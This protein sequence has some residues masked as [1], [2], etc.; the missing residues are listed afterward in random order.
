MNN[1][2]LKKFR[3]SIEITKA[4]KPSKATG[5]AF[6]STLIF[7]KNKLISIGVNNYNKT[8]PLIN[9]YNYV[10]PDDL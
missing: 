4:L 2:V 1:S 6:H 3:R 10:R 8:H 5:R 9:K 7:N